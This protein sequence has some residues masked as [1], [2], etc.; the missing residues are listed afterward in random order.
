MR[1]WLRTD[2]HD[3]REGANRRP[4]GE[5]G[6]PLAS[7]ANQR[8]AALCGD[9]GTQRRRVPDAGYMRLE[10]GS[11]RSDY[12]PIGTECPSLSEATT[13]RGAKNYI[14]AGKRVDL[15]VNLLNPE[16]GPRLDRLAKLIASL[17]PNLASHRIVPRKLP[18]AQGAILLAIQQVLAGFLM[19]FKAS[20]Y[21][22]WLGKTWA[23][24]CRVQPSRA[25]WPTTWPLSGSA[26]GGIGW[27]DLSAA[28]LLLP[29]GLVAWHQLTRLDLE[30]TG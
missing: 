29:F 26:E 6:P 19:G 22:G 30:A 25:T 7:D 4:R 1:R 11:W 9:S 18:L 8:G 5:D 23:V 20:R 16:V 14:P 3:L 13:D 24:R 27:P 2:E 12:R 21:V 17:E 10:N 28:W 15:L